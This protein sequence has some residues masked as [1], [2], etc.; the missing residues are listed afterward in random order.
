MLFLSLCANPC[1][2]FPIFSFPVFVLLSSSFLFGKEQGITALL[3][4]ALVSLLVYMLMLR[5]T[6]MDDF[7]SF[8]TSFLDSG[9]P[10][11]PLVSASSLRY[12]Q[13]LV[14]GFPLASWSSALTIMLCMQ[15]HYLM[16]FLPVY[17]KSAYP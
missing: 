17:S 5:D 8:R 6:K 16:Y 4:S 13:D 7:E 2:L 9:S 12:A 11:L 10:C 3:V 15:A 14:P 1:S